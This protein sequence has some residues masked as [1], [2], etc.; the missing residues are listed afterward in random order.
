MPADRHLESLLPPEIKR[1]IKARAALEGVKIA[2]VVAKACADYVKT[3]ISMDLDEL[4]Q[5]RQPRNVV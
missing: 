5:G 3:P 2:E 1:A 4:R